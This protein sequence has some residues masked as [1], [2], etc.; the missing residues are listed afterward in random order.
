MRVADSEHRVPLTRKEPTEAAQTLGIFQAPTG[1]MTA[2][3]AYLTDKG[4]AFANGYRRSGVMEN[5]DA[6]HGFLSTIMATWRY[7][8]MAITLTFD[9]WDDVVRTALTAALNKSGISRMFPRAAIFGPDLFQGMGV[10]HPFHF[11][12]LEHWE[13]ILRCGNTSSTTGGLIQVSLEELRLEL[14]LPGMITE[15]DYYRFQQ[16]ATDCWMKTVWKYGWDHALDLADQLPQLPLR[17]EN[18]QYL[19]EVF[20]D[21]CTDPNEL[22]QLNWC[23]T[24]LQAVTV[25]DIATADGK[26]IRQAAYDGIPSSQRA[27]TY[28]FPRQ[29][30]SLPK[31]YWTTWQRFLSE[32]LLKAYS[33]SP[34]GKDLQQPLGSWLIDPRE[35]WHWFYRPTSQEL[36]ERVGSRWK[37]YRSRRSS[38]TGSCFSHR[39]HDGYTSTLPPDSRPACVT[40]VAPP[41]TGSQTDSRVRLTSF[42][43][44]GSLPQPPPVP[45]PINL[46]E[47]I[48]R[49]DPNLQWAVQDMCLGPSPNNIQGEN[50]VMAIM[51]HKGRG[52][53]D[54]SYKTHHGTASFGLYGMD[55]T[56]AITG[57]NVTPGQPSDQCPYRSEVGGLLGLLV[58][59]EL[60]CDL[61]QLT[62]GT[63]TIGCDCE[64]A[65]KKLE[66]WAT[67]NPSDHHYDLLLECR[68]I[69]RRLPIT[70][71]FH[72]VEG[73]QDDK[74]RVPY[75]AL[76]WWG[77][78]NCD[79]DTRAKRHWRRTHKQP[80]SPIILPSEHYAVLLAGDKLANFDKLEV[81][82][83]TNAK[84]IREYWQ[85]KHNWTDEIFDDINWPAAKQ[86]R[87]ELPMGQRRWHS[88]FATSHCATGRMMKRRKQWAHDRCPR[89][90]A[91]DED[92]KH[93]CLCPDSDAR[94]VWDTNIKSLDAWLKTQDTAPPVHHHILQLLRLWIANKPP[95]AIPP[96]GP[97]TKA[98]QAQSD[99]GAWHTLLGRISLQLTQTQERHY[100]KTRSQRSGFRWTVEVI[101]KLQYIAWDMWDH[102]NAVLH[103][104]PT[105]HFQRDEL[106]KVNQLIMTEW[107]TGPQG[108]L[109]QDLFLFRS[110]ATVQAKPLP[111]K[112]DWLDAVTNAR[113]AAAHYKEANDEFASERAGIRAWLLQRSS[114]RGLLRPTNRTIPPETT[115]KGRKPTKTTRK[116]NTRTTKQ[117]PRNTQRQNRPTATPTT[118]NTTRTRKR[119]SS[120]PSTNTKPTKIART[121][122]G[123]T[124]PRRKS[125][126]KTPLMANPFK[127]K[128]GPPPR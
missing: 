94:A 73:H 128:D 125:T 112:L 79:M 18:D 106:D 32:H 121:H 30:P 119:K 29:P 8:A 19:M 4:A 71:K 122:A 13:T 61:F 124:K 81:H 9:Q 69:L 77:Q 39:R 24:F 55:I 40:H 46:Q 60:L 56:R 49:L 27:N 33:R 2:Q 103:N 72:W 92:T 17:R 118:G 120:S 90:G 62:E 63:F 88:K 117:K 34:Q 66:P 51:I 50:V 87:K 115:K 127:W 85:K 54:G 83:R 91:T 59:L 58:V 10:I 26:G 12:E 7:P 89:C 45:P 75:A 52:V 43:R 37:I 82:E 65:L 76:D 23:R 97:R 100:I 102:R 20:S 44:T 21:Y 36:Y 48:A 95:P 74:K 14:G 42:D 116:R 107:E 98:L 47:A 111:L 1:D 99:L 108:L 114:N 16:C 67:L 70:I 28:E 3:E 57:Y 25:A 22:Q 101:K 41:R 35:C 68:Q 93:V 105:R 113:A 96:I 84:P 104:D 123:T 109:A 80:P 78:R 5:N 64:S 86:A 38:R 126:P 110:L 6:W 31:A 15:W 53:A 11:Q